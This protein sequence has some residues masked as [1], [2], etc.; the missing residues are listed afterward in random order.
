Y[1]AV[2]A[3]SSITI[4][5]DPAHVSWTTTGDDSG[6]AGWQS[7]DDEIDAIGAIECTGSGVVADAGPDQTG[8]VGDEI[9]FDGSASSGD[10]DHMGWD[11]NG[12][13]SIDVNG[14]TACVPCDV[15]KE[16]DARLFVTGTWGDVAVDTAHYACVGLDHFLLY[17]VKS[18]AESAPFVRFA[19]VT[20][21]DQFGAA[22]Y[23]VVKPKYLG[24][25]SDKNG[26]GVVDS[27]THLMDYQVKP[28]AGSPEFANR[29]DVQIRNQCNTLRLEVSKAVSILVPTL[30]SLVAPPPA[31]SVA[32]HQ[33]DHYLCYKA[34]AQTKLADDTKLPK[35]P[36]GIQVLVTDQFQTEPRRYDLKKIRR[37]CSPVDKSGN[38][39]IVSGRNKGEPVT[40]TSA[41]I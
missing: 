2:H 40:I 26:Q 3:N 1:V 24:L 32:E 15:R 37:L 9:C 11:V 23:Q 25:S 38:P 4:F 30:K 27:M 10:I 7:F 6:V 35:F 34:K 39:V 31:P 12:D 5:D 17:K 16:G 41:A 14:T 21:A 13:G 36:K 33:V 8:R 28:V 18:K 19:P 22:G 20:L 29:S